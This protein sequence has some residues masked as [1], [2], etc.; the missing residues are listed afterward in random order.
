MSEIVLSCGSKTEQIPVMPTDSEVSFREKLCNA[1]G[2]SANTEITGIKNTRTGRI[3]SVEE[4][5]HNPRLLADAS[6]TVIIGCTGLFSRI[7]SS[8]VS[9]IAESPRFRCRTSQSVCLT[10]R[11]P[12]SNI[13][14]MNAA[15]MECSVFETT[16]FCV[17]YTLANRR[18]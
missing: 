18:L 5:A 8:V 1:F 16:S 17:F 3:Y 9:H 11:K 13:F 7:I 15:T 14:S 12:C 4:I 2:I 10:S 6:G